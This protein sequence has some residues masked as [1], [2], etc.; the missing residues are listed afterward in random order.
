[1]R[2]AARRPVPFE[3]WRCIGPF[4]TGQVL[5]DLARVLNEGSATEMRAAAL[6]LAASPDPRAAR[7]LAQAPAFSSDI[8][9]RRLSWATL[10]SIHRT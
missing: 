8:E 3:I 7:L 10:H 6:A 9:Q 1:E 2:A 4:A 5:D